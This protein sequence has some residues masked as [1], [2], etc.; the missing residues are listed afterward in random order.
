[1]LILI[2][3]LPSMAHAD[4]GVNLPEGVTPISNKIYGLHMT[5]FWVC[6]AI[7]VVVFSVMIYS[8][9]F[10]RKSKGA[11]A[12]NFHESTAI[13]LVWTLVPL[14]ILIMIAVPATRVLIDLEN[15]DEA[16]MTVKITGYQWKWQ[17]E[18]LDEKISFFSNLAKGAR[19]ATRDAEKRGSIDHYLL[20]VDKRLVLPINKRIRFLMTSN[21]V[22]HSWWVRDLGVKQDANPGFINDSWA[23]ITKPGIYRGQCAELCGKDHGFMPIVVEAK[24]QEDY[25]VWIKEQ[26]AIAAAAAAAGDREWTKDEL[27]VK[28]QEVY[29]TSCAAC[30]G[31]TGQGVPG[32]FPAMAGSK[33]VTG[34]VKE[35]IKTVMDGR[36]GT[37]MQA[38]KG[39]L[40]D[41]AMAA[42]ITYERNAFG[43]NTGDLVQPATIKAAR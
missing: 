23:T 11:V 15:T 9:I 25:D 21:D 20:N 29:S 13:E 22:I 14:A 2:V 12:A 18:Y 39:Q 32:A 26:K 40:D 3:C 41:A 24:T 27:M 16:E 43:N 8:M 6:V 10:H 42:V 30:H 38:F 7:G 4:F 37:A 17:Y 36:A 19:E 34:D 31:V 28:G 33:V 1:M 5:I 35:H